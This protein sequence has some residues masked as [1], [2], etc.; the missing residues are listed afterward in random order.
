MSNC[1]RQGIRIELLDPVISSQAVASAADPTSL[2]YIPGAML[3]GLYAN[4]IYKTAKDRALELLHSAGVRFLDGLP[5]TDHG[6]GFPLPMSIHLPKA[7]GPESLRDL[8][9]DLTVD[10]YEPDLK[11]QRG[12]AIASGQS[13][14]TVKFEASLRT[15]ITP[16]LGVAAE[17]QFY[18]LNA[19]CAGQQFLAVIEGNTESEVNGVA[20]FLCGVSQ[21]G[22]SPAKKHILGR[23]KSAEFGTCR[24]SRADAWELTHDK[25][26]AQFIWCLSD[27]AAVDEYGLPTGHPDTKFFG[28]EIDWRRSFLRHRRYAPY[29]AA[30]NTRTPERLVIERGSVFTLKTAGLGAGLH[31]LGLHQE[32]GLGLVFASSEPPK[33]SIENLPALPRKSIASRKAGVKP[34]QVEL[35]KWLQNDLEWRNGLVGQGSRPGNLEVAVWKGHYLAAQAV[36]GPD[37][38]PAASQ[39]G[40]LE[41]SKDPKGELAAILADQSG[42]DAKSWKAHFKQGD[43][44]TFVQ[45][46]HSAC[47]AM[48]VERFKILAKEIRVMLIKGVEQDGK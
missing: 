10:E 17:G 39:W 15:A 46:A 48:G 2:P 23:S 14:A 36:F 18:T 20:D 32:T 40:A 16:D 38:G 29:N 7:A 33:I 34:E 45:A 8:K 44:G 35:I 1:F 25:Q 26:Q 6:P 11:Q 21:G 27:L 31:M 12:W 13:P 3:W 30:W 9:C 4:H 19:L 47:D 22:N 5:L 37:V 24:L 42:K 28:A 41:K 43:A